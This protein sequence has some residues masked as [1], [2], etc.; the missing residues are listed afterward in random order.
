MS[1]DWTH[2]GLSNHI[3]TL[4]WGGTKPTLIIAG[5]NAFGYERIQQNFNES[6]FEGLRIVEKFRDKV[7]SSLNLGLRAE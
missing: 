2:A 5:G 6:L 1:F 7:C 4:N 3:N